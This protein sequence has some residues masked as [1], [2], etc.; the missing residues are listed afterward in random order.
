MKTTNLKASNNY[1]LNLKIN[2]NRLI[3]KKMFSKFSIVLIALSMVAGSLA[4]DQY[5]QHTNDYGRQ[6]IHRPMQQTYGQASQTYAKVE[7]RPVVSNVRE[8]KQE[9][10]QQHQFYPQQPIY[11]QQPVH[12]V[13]NVYNTMPSYSIYQQEPKIQ[14]VDVY[15]LQQQK[16]QKEALESNI[17]VPIVALRTPLVRSPTPAEAKRNLAAAQSAAAKL[18]GR[19]NVATLDVIKPVYAS[20]QTYSAQNAY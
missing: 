3:E 7:S 4:S 13:E 6:Y 1:L 15:A 9:Y 10:L 8:Q 11:S 19:K 16:R 20:V 2:I 12:R 5:M 14:H 17:V 18:N